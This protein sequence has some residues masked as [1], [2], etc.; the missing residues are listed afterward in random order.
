M[1]MAA[2]VTVAVVIGAAAAAIALGSRASTPAVP[3]TTTTSVTTVTP[4]SDAPPVP[5]A[6]VSWKTCDGNDGPTDEQCA[7]L[8][9][10]LNYAQ[11]DGAKIGI[12]LARQRATGHKIGSLVMNP[13][14]PGASGIDELSYLASLLPGSVTSRFDIVSFDPRGVARSDPVRC[15]T[16]PELDQFIHLNPAPTT[17]VGFNQLLAA[18]RLFDQRCEA[19]SGTILPYVGTVNVARDM[20]E[21]R[22]A[23]GD[24][25]LTY[26]GFSYGTFLGATYADLF[27]THI[28]AMVLDGA[29]DPD[30][31]PISANI[32]QATGFDQELTSFFAYCTANSSC[33]W[34]PPGD[35]LSAD[36][37]A[38]M[39]RIGAHPLPGSGTRTLGPGEAFFGVAQELYDQ[40]AWPDLANGLARADAGDGS[41]LL[42]FSD[43]YTG[44]SASGAYD[45]SIEANNAISC[46]DEPW[47]RDPAVLEQ[48]AVTAK[49]EAPVFG[50]ADLY[51]A[52]TCTDWPAPATSTPHVIRAA[53]SPPIVVV[54][55]TGD[56]ATPY[57][58]SVALAGQLTHGLLITRVGDGHTGY[59][60]SQCVRNYV[61]SYLVNLTVPPE[62]VRCP[63][64]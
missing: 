43:D 38:L 3:A 15:E 53:A 12:A 52:L 61:N 54:G 16:G 22:A 7:T 25:T 59:R 30:A 2:L 36:F 4:V 14:G 46:V 8:M 6:P 17:E 10:P 28:R 62:G 5:V 64:P 56:P 42:Q 35:H 48:A 55:S 47:P 41:L 32:E 29:L 37:T 49:K 19:Q 60:S 26:F 51:G 50:V 63:S 33:P 31:D 24:A 21:I 34:H 1:V 18:S 45:N 27:P 40:A 39:A 13:G 20:D 11:P 57:A 44:R 23:V 58:D 9:V